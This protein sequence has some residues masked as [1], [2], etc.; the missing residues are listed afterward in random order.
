LLNQS[1]GQPVG[2]LQ[3][4]LYSA[5][6]MGS[7]HQITS[8][9]NGA[10][11]AHAGWNACTGLGSPDGNDLLSALKSGPPSSSSAS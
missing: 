9:S 4:F 8:G 11:S 1:L 2:F 10:Y 6:G 7:L 3:P 5:K